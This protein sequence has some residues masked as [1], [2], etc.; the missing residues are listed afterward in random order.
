MLF[1]HK[2]ERNPIICDNTDK[3]RRLCTP[4]QS[5]SHFRQECWSG[6]SFPL[7]G[8]LPHPG[9]ETASLASPALAGRFFTAKPPK[10]P[11]KTSC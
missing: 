2:K 10:N 6:F 5:L 3:P 4:A 11:Q 1:S 9:I 8:D 7:P